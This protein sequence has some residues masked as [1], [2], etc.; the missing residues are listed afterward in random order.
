MNLLIT[1][2]NKLLESMIG[3]Y[4]NYF[5]RQDLYQSVSASYN[6]DNLGRA[7]VGFITDLPDNVYGAQLVEKDFF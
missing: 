1:P 7:H 5:I 3:F 2:T 4:K 6:C